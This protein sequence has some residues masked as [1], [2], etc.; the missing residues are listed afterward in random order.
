MALA[1]PKAAKG[2]I[3]VKN[4]SHVLS[5]IKKVQKLL[6]SAAM[7]AMRKS[8]YIVEGEAI[9]L[10]SYD[11]KLKAVDTGRMK[12]TITSAVTEISAKHL[13]GIVGVGTHYA[14]Y[15]HEG[16]HKMGA[17]P[18]LTTALRNKK[19]AIFNLF[20]HHVSRELKGIKY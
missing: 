17:R 11:E 5:R 9:R 2:L 20:K 12:S 18:F 3:V 10:V 13:Y 7:T 6:P 1:L 19:K 15:V 16:T 8:L 14:I 4:I